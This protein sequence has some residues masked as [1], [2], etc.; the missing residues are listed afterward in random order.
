[1][2]NRN[3]LELLKLRNALLDLQKGQD[4]VEA[5]LSPDF[6]ALRPPLLE[7][8]LL[9]VGPLHPGHLGLRQVL[10]QRRIRSTLVRLILWDNGR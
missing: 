7:G 2:Q 10:L 3:I 4:K 8:V 1:M 6:L 5:K 9:L